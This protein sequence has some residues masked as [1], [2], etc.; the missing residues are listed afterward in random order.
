MV[1]GVEPSPDKMLQGRLFAYA[2][3]HRYRLTA[4]YATLPINAAKCPVHH[5]GRDGSMRFD[6]NFGGAP[7]YEPNSKGGPVEDRREVE[8]PMPLTGTTGA[9][10]GGFDPLALGIGVVAALALFRFKAGVIPVILA[11]GA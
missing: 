10:V 4:N 9:P 5:Y 6:G 7:N 1:P 11:C 3:A 8:A 2:D